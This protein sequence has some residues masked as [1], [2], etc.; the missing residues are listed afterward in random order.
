MRESVSVCV[1]LFCACIHIY[2]HIY[3]NSCHIWCN[4]GMVY[5][6]AGGCLH[7]SLYL[8]VCVC[9]CGRIRR[10]V[11][12]CI[13]VFD[14]VSAYVH[15]VKCVYTACVCVWSFIERSCVWGRRTWK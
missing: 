6:F 9:M 1:G 13:C 4:T 11:F 14:L 10:Q 2:T 7:Q 12:Q 15:V 8:C 5:M 3:A